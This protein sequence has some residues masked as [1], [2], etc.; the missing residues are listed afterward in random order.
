MTANQSTADTPKAEKKLLVNAT[1]EPVKAG[2]TLMLVYSPAMV[3]AQE[4]YLLAAR[5]RDETP[6]EVTIAATKPIRPVSM[7]SLIC[8]NARSAALRSRA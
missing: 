7:A 1:A 5:L 3:Q 2:Q 8:R 6:S 4:E